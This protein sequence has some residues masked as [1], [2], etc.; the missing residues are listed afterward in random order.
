MF[1]V[2]QLADATL[3]FIRTDNVCTNR[4]TVV[5]RCAV[6][7]ETVEVVAHSDKWIDLAR[8][9]YRLKILHPEY[10]AYFNTICNVTLGLSAKMVTFYTPFFDL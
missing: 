3:T 10:A 5:V 9:A 6:H 7:N 2:Q 1:K 8:E 4:P